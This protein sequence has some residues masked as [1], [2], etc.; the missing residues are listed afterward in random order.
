MAWVEAPLSQN[1]RGS[2]NSSQRYL[3]GECKAPPCFNVA[4][5]YWRNND[6]NNNSEPL[7]NAHLIVQIILGG[8]YYLGE[9][10]LEV[11]EPQAKHRDVR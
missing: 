4:I 9:P 1:K 3:C 2:E 6:R 8:K 11:E 7:W 5:T 10:H